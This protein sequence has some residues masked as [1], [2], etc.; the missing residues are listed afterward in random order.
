M[1]EQQPVVKETKPKERIDKPVMKLTDDEL[2]EKIQKLTRIVFSNN[3][4][5]AQQARPILLGLY[6]E[7]GRRN[8]LKFEE[9]LKKNG[10]NMEE[11]I[12][13]DIG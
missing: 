8:S 9:H 3:Y 7:Q 5:L 12:N 6:D 2:D 4:N 11:I 10:T 13:I 1:A